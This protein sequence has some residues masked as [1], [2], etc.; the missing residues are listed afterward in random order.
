MECGRSGKEAERAAGSFGCPVAGNGNGAKPARLT[1]W[2]CAVGDQHGHGVESIERRITVAERR[3]RYRFTVRERF[4]PLLPDEPIGV[5]ALS[6]PVDAKRLDAGLEALRAWGH[7]VVLAPNLRFRDGY[8]AGDDQARLE[9]LHWV[10]DRG[11]RV[12][13]A[14]RGGYG[15][16]RLLHRLDW[17]RLVD[18]GTSFVGYSDLTALMNA[19]VMRGGDVQVHGPMV[20]AGLV[21]NQNSAH[22]RSLLEGEIVGETI[23]RFPR[24]SVVAGGRARGSAL[25]GNLAV[26]AALL[27]TPFEPSFEGSVLFLEEVGE[28]LYRLDRMLT[29]LSCADTFQRV[30]ALIGGSL[31]GCRP[32]AERSER[33]RT[34][35]CEV[36]P[37]DA[38]IVVDL[39]FGHG[40]RN[41]GFPIG[42]QVEIDTDAGLVTW[43]G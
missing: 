14:A 39:P 10:L 8:L 32:A 1:A 2:C 22:L 21:S 24:S 42:S 7:P 4:Q 25:G 43:S 18:A 28:P 23:F 29:Q 27:G 5:V 3:L 12:V 31:R 36:A 9:G 17:D 33:W 40:S 38:V 20:A 26:L 37:P 13:I 11:P 19:L 35:L 34:L 41:M 16:T 30:K 6:G 15:V